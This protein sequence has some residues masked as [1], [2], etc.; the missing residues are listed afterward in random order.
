TITNGRAEMNDIGALL[1]NGQLLW[2]FPHTVSA[3]FATGAFLIAGI[4]AFYLLKRREVSF[5]RSSFIIAII[6]AFVSSAA[7]AYFG[8]GQAKYLVE[9]QP[10]KMAASEGLWNT[11]DDPAPWTVFAIIDTDEMSNSFE[12]KIPYILSFL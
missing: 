8:H 3:A 4:S 7:V 5:F 6:V 2:E 10:M 9:T 1:T 11:S 12:I